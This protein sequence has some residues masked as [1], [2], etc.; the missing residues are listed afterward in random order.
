[1][2][3]AATVASGVL[4]AADGGSDPSGGGG[5]R[6]DSSR[7]A[8]DASSTGDTL[9]YVES[10]IGMAGDL[11][12]LIMPWV[13]AGSQYLQMKQQQNNFDKTFAE[14]QKRFGL[15]F[16]LKEW[17]TRKGFEFQKANKLWNEKV[18]SK[19]ANLNRAATRENLKSSGQQRMF[20]AE[21]MAW[22]RKDR[23]KSEKVAKAYS[24]GLLK[25]LGGKD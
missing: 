14:N 6:S 9:G 16:A 15:N 11:T 22:M 25:G 7:T 19:S 3:V 5:L 20:D 13:N 21:K 1:M 12:N 18:Q 17:A 2:A 10:G 4:G 24:K 23:E 8:E